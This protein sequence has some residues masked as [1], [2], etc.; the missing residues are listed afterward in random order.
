MCC[1]LAQ[2]LRPTCSARCPVASLS[3]RPPQSTRWRSAKSSDASR[4]PNVSTPPSSVESFAGKRQ[5]P[6]LFF[7][8]ISHS[9]H[10]HMPPPSIRGLDCLG[11]DIEKGKIQID[12]PVSFSVK[13]P[14]TAPAVVAPAGAGLFGY[15]SGPIRS[16]AGRVPRHRGRG[17]ARKR[18]GILVWKTR[19]WWKVWNDD[20]VL[21]DNFKEYGKKIL[22]EMRKFKYEEKEE[23][24]SVFFLNGQICALSMAFI[25]LVF[26]FGSMFFC[27]FFFPLS[28]FCFY[29]F[30]FQHREHKR[31]RKEF[32]ITSSLF[33]SKVL[34]A[35]ESVQVSR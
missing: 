18:K 25:F 8:S 7:I 24:E 13:R 5:P 27:R 30:L 3:S 11:N 23:P 9:Q 22:R 26:F 28:S 17:S 12:L 19:K 33:F 29:T 20:S 1:C 2:F 32:G 16:V 35:H 34:L 6:S 4:R 21:T 15:L 10:V 14:A 31:D